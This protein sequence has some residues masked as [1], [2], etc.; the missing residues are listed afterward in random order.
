MSFY[1]SCLTNEQ[2]SEHVERARVVGV[3][4]AWAAS[5][6][7]VCGQGVRLV[8]AY[9]T[10][11]S[12]NPSCRLSAQHPATGA[13]QFLG[14]GPTPDAARAAAAKAIESGTVR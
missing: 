7:K 10:L 1:E 11:A 6:P 5:Q 2:V 9:N 8:F 4:D 12:G 13:D 14:E 3:L